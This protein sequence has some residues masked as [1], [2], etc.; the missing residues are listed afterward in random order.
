MKDLNKVLERN[1]NV[2][3]LGESAEIQHKRSFSD[4]VKIMKTMAGMAND[5]GGHILI[6]GANPASLSTIIQNLIN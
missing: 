5:K 1:G 6:G 4:R 2:L 3:K